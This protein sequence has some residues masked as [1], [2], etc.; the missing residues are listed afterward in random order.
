MLQVRLA[1]DASAHLPH[2]QLKLPSAG[3]PRADA[4][5]LSLGYLGD[6]RLNFRFAGSG[7]D[8]LVS[9]LKRLGISPAQALS[10]AVLNHKRLHGD[11]SFVPVSEGVYA[12]QC[13]DPAV[14]STFFLDRR[15]WKQLL[16][17]YPDGVMVAVPREGSVLFSPA[18]DPDAHRRL[19]EPAAR[20]L[21]SAGT[22]RVSRNLYHFGP[23]GWHMAGPLIDPAA[24]RRQQEASGPSPD[25]EQAA[26]ATGPQVD[27]ELIASGQ[28]TL[29]LGIGLGFLFN[30][31]INLPQ[32][33]PLA[34][35]LAWLALGLLRLKG[36]TRMGVGLAHSR[37]WVIALMVMNFVPLVNL[38]SWIVINVR[39]MKIL[40]AE[41]Y[42][43][44][45]L[46]A[47]RG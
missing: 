33:P 43:I 10:L 25:A 3:D 21:S 4:H 19:R 46:G 20:M 39:A 44:G 47:K 13:Q 45:L 27:H 18:G 38:L 42:R 34:G 6:I 26:D 15:L 9:D 22:T 5:R 16:T 2:E 29:I 24:A 14:C 8:A 1:N 40:R 17:K 12:L 7:R 32:V 41:G 11:A 30:R 23:T 36:V 37:G 28:R 31:A 35:D